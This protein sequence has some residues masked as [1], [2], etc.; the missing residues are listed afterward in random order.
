MDCLYI[1]AQLVA[2]GDRPL[3]NAPGDDKLR[4]G[5]VEHLRAVGLHDD[6]INGL[7]DNLFLEAP[8]DAALPQLKRIDDAL[9]AKPRLGGET[10]KRH[11]KPAPV[12]DDLA[13]KMLDQIL[14]TPFG[15]WFEFV[16]NQQG[17][18]V[19]RKEGK[20]FTSGA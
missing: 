11:V 15:T 3:G 12:L 5:A 16:K 2:R 14:H 18:T 9:R 8:T 1:A 13:R 7:L 17:E 20:S 10:P 19:R 6:E 4:Q